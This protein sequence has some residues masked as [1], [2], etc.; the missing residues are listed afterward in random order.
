VSNATVRERER[1][2]HRRAMDG[3]WDGVTFHSRRWRLVPIAAGLAVAVLVA[4]TG[5]LFVWPTPTVKQPGRADAVIVLA[6]GSGDRLIKAMALMHTGIARKLFIF[7][8]TDRGWVAAHALCGTTQTDENGVGFTVTCPEA[9]PNT[10]R[11]EA[12]WA[13]SQYRDNHWKSVVVVTSR[14]NLTRARL[15]MDRCLG[16]GFIMVQS[17]PHDAIITKANHVLHE[18][19]GWLRDQTLQRSC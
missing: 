12:R 13:R 11:G 7:D 1:E 8:G 10:S 6:G 16:S 18:W 5:K 4:L 19:V 9:K 2:R 17:T 14:Y 15:A 3:D